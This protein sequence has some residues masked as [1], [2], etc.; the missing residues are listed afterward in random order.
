VFAFIVGL[1]SIH[2]LMKWLANHSTYIF[3]YYRIALGV[4]VMVLLATGTIAATN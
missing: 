2:W 3:I 4:L 1:A